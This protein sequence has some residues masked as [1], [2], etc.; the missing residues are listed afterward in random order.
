MTSKRKWLWGLLIPSGILILVALINGIFGLFGHRNSLSSSNTVT[1]TN[2]NHSISVAGNQTGNNTIDD[3]STTMPQTISVSQNQAPIYNAQNAPINIYYGAISNSVTKEAFEALENNLV[4]ATNKIE[5]TAN[6]VH[7]LAQALRDLD[8]RTADIE[9]L[10]DGRTKFGSIVTGKPKTLI[11]AADAGFQNYTNHNYGE[12]LPYFQ[13]AIEIFEAETNQT[14]VMMESGGL[15]SLGKGQL[16]AL[17]AD[18]MLHLTNYLAANEFAEKAVRE[19][20]NAENNL[21]VA[22]SFGSLGRKSLANEDYTSALEA[23]RKSFDAYQASRNAGDFQ[24]TNV[25][26]KVVAGFYGLAAQTAQRLGSNDLA[27]EYATN[28][29]EIDSTNLMNQLLLA[30]TLGK[31]GRKDEAVAVIDKAF[32]TESNNPAATRFK[33]IIRAG[34]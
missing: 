20:P 19:N 25:N 34:H 15:T 28:L 23:F 5:L 6:E 30:S 32:G 22:S 7:L 3:H 29:V 1:G 14:D 8:Q 4:T 9:K 12:A 33:E 27:Y 21:A 26:M 11:E 18:C 13:K 16:Y 17:T 10:P 2:F 31:V 24:I